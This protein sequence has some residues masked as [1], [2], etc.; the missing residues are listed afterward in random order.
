MTPSELL[1]IDGRWRPSHAPGLIGVEDPVLQKTV[2]RVPDGVPQDVDEAV[3]AAQRALDP[4]ARTDPGLR[5]DFVAG[6]RRALSARREEFAAA[7]RTETGSPPAFARRM[8]VGLPLRQLGVLL[9]VLATPPEPE[10]IGH[11]WVVREPAGV[12][13]AITPWNYPLAQALLKVA[14]ALA[15]GC[16]V[17]LKPSELAPL[18]AVLLAE[19]LHGIGL[20]PG[21]FNLVSGRG[22]V[23]GE[24][25]AA[26]PGVDLVSFTGSTRAGRRVATLAGTALN[27]VVLELGGKSACL[28]L[29]G[30]DLAGAVR[31]AVSSCFLNS[32][33]TCTALSRLLVHESRYERA[34]E[35]AATEA[36]RYTLGTTEGPAPQLGPLVSAAQRERVLG[37]LR[38]GIADGA[39]LVAGGPDAPVPERGYYVAPTVL[40]DV[41]PRAELAQE[42]VFGPVL[43]VI[44]FHDEEEGVRLANDSRYGLSGAVW[45]DGVEE[46]LRVARR[47]RTGRVS[48]NGAPVAPAAPFGG[49]KQSGFGREAGRYGLEEFQVLRTFPFPRPDPA[50]LSGPG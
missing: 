36:A 23:V 39:R 38:R 44:A 50:G 48:L 6:L 32:G 4:W 14:P 42:E 31:H 28:V 10:R 43:S 7:I 1:Y 33:Q 25:L 19:V 37:Y 8:Q 49:L 40:A 13:A 22:A 17:V 18:S 2:A 46:A 20:P 29:P 45:A 47:L 35:L 21:V 34:V 9:D 12:V 30:A 3:A 16:T 15:A 5:R 26:H 11:A 27:R 41:H 24:A